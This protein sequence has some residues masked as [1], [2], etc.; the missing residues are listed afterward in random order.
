MILPKF[1]QL[2][3][4]LLAGYLAW[5]GWDRLGPRTPDPGE[6]RQQA[7]ERAASV[8]AEDLRLHRGEVGAVLMVPFAG[9]PSGLFNDRLRTT[10]EQRG[11]L[12]L[13]P[14]AWGETLQVWTGQRRS[15][16]ASPHEAIEAGRASGAS[17][18]LFGRLLVFE[19]T[20]QRALLEVEYALTDVPS[21]ETIHRGSYSSS[22]RSGETVA[23][24]SALLTRTVP[25]LQRG[26]GWIVVVLLLP[27][28]TIS[29]I[30]TMVARRSNGINAF[31]LSIYTLAGAILAYL[32]LGA[33]LPALWAAAVV[34]AATLIAL[35][36]N[37]RIMSLAVRLEE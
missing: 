34:V 26:L 20:D 4:L 37:V 18:V 8:I 24:Q 21:G 10:L 22:P 36:Y 32:L 29:F 9:D 11:T 1:S 2:G 12:D 33:A 14:R 31:V 30:R 6:L 3:T 19:A 35:T 28:F 25:W 15:T 16:A 13:Q 23:E 17:A 27:V 7:A 5:I